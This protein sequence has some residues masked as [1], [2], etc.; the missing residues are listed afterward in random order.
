MLTQT[1]TETLIRKL[2]LR[3]L[4]LGKKTWCEFIFHA[5]GG[6]DDHH[7]NFS[8][9][10]VSP[11]LSSGEIYPTSQIIP[12]WFSGDLTDDK[13][14]DETC[15]LNLSFLFCHVWNELG[16]TAGT[17]LGS[18]L[19]RKMLQTQ[20]RDRISH[21]VMSDSFWFHGLQPTR[22]LCPWDSLG[23]S[24]G[25]GCHALLQGIFL[26]QRSNPGLPHCGQ[27]LY[28]LSH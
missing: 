16:L 3:F 8:S 2:W 24:T 28:Y 13:M 20:K 6:V 26:T 10:N 7:K 17:D 23:K 25:V 22:L 4:C 27:I 5:T 11:Y 21:S 9:T 12:I 19:G 1:L 15:S 14:K 18:E